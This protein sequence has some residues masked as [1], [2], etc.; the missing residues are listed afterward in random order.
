[1]VSL[2]MNIEYLFVNKNISSFILIVK[3]YD[4]LF[5]ECQ[6]NVFHSLGLNTSL[7]SSIFLDKQT[8]YSSMNIHVD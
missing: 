4:L 1:M 8:L 2:E 5:V 7:L 6:K 3:Q